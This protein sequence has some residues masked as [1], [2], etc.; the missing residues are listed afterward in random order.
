VYYV[1]FWFTR[2]DNSFRGFVGNLKDMNPRLI[3]HMVEES[4]KP[5]LAVPGEE[6]SP[7]SSSFILGAFDEHL[8]VG[9][10]GGIL[11]ATRT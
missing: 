3:T 10:L 7:V 11:P 2:R 8:V 4:S 9:F 5:T 6:P 1:A